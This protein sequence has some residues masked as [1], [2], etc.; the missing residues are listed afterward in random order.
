MANFQFRRGQCSTLAGI[1]ELKQMMANLPV[2]LVSQTAVV[3]SGPAHSSMS[4]PGRPR[5][6]L[7]YKPPTLSIGWPSLGIRGS[8]IP[9]SQGPHWDYCFAIQVSILG[10]Y[11]LVIAA[12][13]R[14]LPLCRTTFTLRDPSA[15]ALARF[16]GD[17]DEFMVACD[18]GDLLTVR[19][20]LQ[21]GRARITDVGAGKWTPLT[22]SK[23]AGETWSPFPLPTD[24][25]SSPFAVVV[26]KS[27]RN[28]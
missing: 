10:Y 8:I 15:F 25:T 2:A 14:T 27:W 3:L 1:D 13:V 7:R 18:R 17:D 24:D 26:L 21:D 4:T 9:T 5:R 20:M 16:V 23:S 6:L 12:C 28:C 11:V 19:S 22:V